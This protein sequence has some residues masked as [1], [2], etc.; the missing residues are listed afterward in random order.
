[1]SSAFRVTRL[2]ASPALPPLCNG[3]HLDQ[4]TFHARYEAMPEHVRAEL[5][6][7]IVY[8]AS[9]QKIAHGFW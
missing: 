6:G 7:G 4:P 1:M 9:P 5:I 2:G 3:D 8:M